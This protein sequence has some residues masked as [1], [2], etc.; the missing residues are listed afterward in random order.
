M[1]HYAIGSNLSLLDKKMN[2]GDRAYALDLGGLNEQP[3]N[4][5]IRYAGHIT[6]S[7]TFPVH[8]HSLP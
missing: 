3:S 6:V 4:A 2:L 7:I 5:Q 8:P 1:P